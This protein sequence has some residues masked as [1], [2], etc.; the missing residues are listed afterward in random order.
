MMRRG[1]S[2]NTMA[3]AFAFVLAEVARK[4][5]LGEDKLMLAYLV[6]VVFML[7]QVLVLHLTLMIC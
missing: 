5:L 3:S 1:T 4:T 6:V 7:L 2:P